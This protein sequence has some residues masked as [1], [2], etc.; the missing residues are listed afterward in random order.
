MAPLCSTSLEI[1]HKVKDVIKKHE[2]GGGVAVKIEHASYE[3]AKQYGR[4]CECSAVLEPCAGANPFRFLVDENDELVSM[5]SR[6]S[7][8][9]LK[10]HFRDDVY[11]FFVGRLPLVLGR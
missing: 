9:T 1:N 7:I 2:A 11:V 8:D 6:T 4:H 10:E 3:S 5:I